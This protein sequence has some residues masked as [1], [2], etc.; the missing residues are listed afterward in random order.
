MS[1]FRNLYTLYHVNQFGEVRYQANHA[2]LASAKNEFDRDQI[3]LKNNDLQNDV[4]EV[5]V[6][7]NAD[8][9]VLTTTTE[10]TNA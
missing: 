2:S 4:V 6:Y 3:H 1:K 7:K 10:R 9:R 5:C 8:E